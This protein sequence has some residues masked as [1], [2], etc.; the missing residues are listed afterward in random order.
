MCQA[1]KFVSFC[2]KNNDIPF[3][4]KKKVFHA[5][6]MSTILYG[7]ESWLNGNIR[8]MENI[9]NM[10]VKHLLGVRKNTTT[11]LCLVEL[12]YP[13]LKALVTHKQRKFFRKMWAERE[14]MLDDPFS[15]AVRL[16]KD[17]NISTARYI[18]N[19][20]G[21]DIDDIS[22]SMDILHQEIIN[23]QSSRC[24][25]YRSINPDMNVHDIYSVK[26]TINEIERTS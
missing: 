25:Y 14:G 16:I 18:N 4:V 24:I 2:Q 5:A 6:V 7:C 1:L 20:I 3:Y 15:H 12:G 11:S 26:T 10:C 9:Y 8:P 23:S 22:Q 19:L 17:T 21:N 13:P